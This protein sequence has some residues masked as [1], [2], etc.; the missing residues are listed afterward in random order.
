MKR[1][2]RSRSRPLV[3]GVTAAAVLG[4]A[5]L[6]FCACGGSL[7]EIASPSPQ[8]TAAAA[9]VTPART[10]AATPAPSPADVLYTVQAGDTVGAIADR[11]GV[12]VDAIVSANGLADAADLSVGQVLTIPGVVA[13]PA[14]SRTPPPVTTAADSPIGIHTAMPV[15]GAC[16]T[17]DDSQMP[18]APRAYRAG[19]HEGVDFFTSY[20]CVEIPKGTQVLAAADGVVIRT[21]HDYRA[22]T[23]Q[24]INDLEAKDLAQ[25]YTDEGS[26]DKFRGRQIWIDHGGGIVTRYCHLAAI[27]PDVQVGTHVVQ[28]QI[29]GYTGDSGTPESASNPDFEIHLHFEIR[30]GKTYLGAGLDPLQ[31]R[32][33]YERAFG[34]PLTQ[35]SPAP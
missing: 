19:V 18:N 16:L 9:A 6:L 15:A 31:T 27:P 24:E 2:I 7:A 5:L 29:I 21:D 8:S 32:N 14:P 12:S 11:F 13:S 4:A 1:A 26:L 34:L 10:P 33:I 3:R 30:V 17:T 22:L 35:P 20:A 28:G 25:G 23:Q